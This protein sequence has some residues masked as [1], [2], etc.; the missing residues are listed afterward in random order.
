MPRSLACLPFGLRS[1]KRTLFGKA[2]E[3]DGCRSM[4][5]YVARGPKC[6]QQ[7]IAFLRRKVREAK[8]DNRLDHATLYE[9]ELGILCRKHHH[10]SLTHW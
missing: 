8:G 6:H 10:V 7:A 1:W 4:N 3:S 5:L 9:L 2:T